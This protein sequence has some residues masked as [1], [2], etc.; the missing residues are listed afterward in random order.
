ME[1]ALNQI[2]ELHKVVYGLPDLAEKNVLG[3]IPLTDDFERSSKSTNRNAFN[4][5]LRII[6]PEMFQQA[7]YEYEDVAPLIKAKME[8]LRLELK[9]ENKGYDLLLQSEKWLYPDAEHRDTGVDMTYSIQY[10]P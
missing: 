10:A 2:T 7:L 3:I 8:A 4:V 1:T 5:A 6:I 9:G